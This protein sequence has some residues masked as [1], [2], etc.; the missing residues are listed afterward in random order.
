MPIDPIFP[1]ASGPS[2]SDSL[3]GPVKSPDRVV[4][5]DA[6]SSGNVPGQP[7]PLPA[8]LVF[9][10]ETEP[11]LELQSVGHQTAEPPRPVGPGFWES[12]AWMIGFP[13]IQ[14]VAMLLA[15]FGLGVLYL[16]NHDVPATM[17][18]SGLFR[19][20]AT[21]VEP[22]LALVMVLAGCCT[23]LYG[24]GA[25]SLRYWR[26]G[27]L[28]GL[29]WQV[30][31]AV[32]L[33]LIVMAA[34]PLALLCTELQK[35][36]FSISPSSE[37]ELEQ[38]LKGLT[39]APLGVI[40]LAIAVAPALGE[41]LL[42]RGLIGRGLIARMGIVRGMLLTSVLFGVMHVNPAQAVAVIP[43]GLAM[44]FVYL[45]TR[46]FWA[47]VLV[48]LLNNSLAS[49]LLKYESQIP[50]AKLLDG[51]GALPL[52]L[53]TVSAAMVTA[54]GLLFWQTRVQYASKDG[55][56]LNSYWPVSGRQPADGVLVEIR[57]TPQPLLLAC[58]A[59]N[60]L[61]FVAVLWRQ[62]IAF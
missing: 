18:L 48:H 6:T 30:P 38:F 28:R 53:L 40:L 43:L 36:M 44:H 26:Q 45:A 49:V 47:P 60:S 27:G 33:A 9:L 61:G 23:V 24:A 19:E 10:A 59:F 8:E 58:G 62:A 34:L 16:A 12:I 7:E 31:S 3:S 41:E 55:T 56:L 22:N 5:Y 29:G 25:V 21:I 20:L 13:L 2:A 11:V 52:H 4:S 17:S 39:Q 54:I 35:S 57:P 15:I 46:S 14:A 50:L 42:F 32:H 1:A 51:E 37:G